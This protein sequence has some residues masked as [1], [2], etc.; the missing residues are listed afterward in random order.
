MGASA[1][2][3]VPLGNVNIHGRPHTHIR[4]RTC[5]NTHTFLSA[6]ERRELIG[7]HVLWSEG[8]T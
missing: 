7:F 1:A 2:K 4:T 5:V 8:E 3:A 6:V